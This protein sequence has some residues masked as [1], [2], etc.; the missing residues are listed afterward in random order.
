MYST[1]MP[2][3]TGSLGDPWEPEPWR[4]SLASRRSDQVRMSDV[5]VS[6]MPMKRSVPNG[7]SRSRKSGWNGEKPAPGCQ[8]WPT[9]RWPP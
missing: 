8:R 9:N 7:A 3:A 4:T 6:C 5:F 2:L 1:D